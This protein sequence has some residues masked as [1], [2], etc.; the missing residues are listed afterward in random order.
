[1]GGAYS[2]EADSVIR[3]IG[4]VFHH[5]AGAF[6]LRYADLGHSGYL[7]NGDSGGQNNRV[8]L[9]AVRLD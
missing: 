7:G 9:H 8:A 5:D 4:F 6:V 2:T 3:G 1:M